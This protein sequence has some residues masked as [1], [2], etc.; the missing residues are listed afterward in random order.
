[1]IGEGM[2]APVE[3]G[4]AP[5]AIRRYRDRSRTERAEL[6]AVLD[7]LLVATLSTVVDGGPCVVPLLVVRDGDRLLLH[8]STGAGALRHVAAGAPAAVSVVHLDGIVVADSTFDS[9]ANY[10]SA[11]VYGT[12]EPIL[13]AEEKRRSLDVISEAILPGRTAE[14]RAMTDKEVAATGV[15]AMEI[16]EGDWLVKTRVGGP[17]A[18]PPDLASSEPD[19]DAVPWTGVVPLS[20]VAGEPVPEPWV[21]AAEVPRSVQERIRLGGAAGPGMVGNSADRPRVD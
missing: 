20:M 16:R 14:V 21:A 4:G 3:A 10:R 17:G 2:G 1:M 19:A 8:G 9:S 5:R 12:L 7:G 13:D 11:V 15:L 6:D 18:A